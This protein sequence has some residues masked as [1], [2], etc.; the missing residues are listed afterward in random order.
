MFLLVLLR[1]ALQGCK[2]HKLRGLGFLTPEAKDSECLKD[3]TLCTVD[4]GVNFID[5]HFA[6]EESSHL[7]SEQVSVGLHT[8]EAP[9]RICVC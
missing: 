5:S 1:S 2:L 3:V 6:S 7:D 9:E 8:Q 4:H